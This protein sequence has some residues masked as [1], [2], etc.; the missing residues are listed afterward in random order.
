M[1]Q[2][3]E[4]LLN[5]DHTLHGSDM[6]SVA[7]LTCDSR[8]VTEGSCFFAIEGTSVDGHNYIGK[9]VE[10]GASVIVC[11][12]LP[13]GFDTTRTSAVVVED[14]DKAMAEIAAAY[15]NYPSRK[16]KVVGV[17]GTNG[18]TTIATLLYDLVRLLG[19][20]AGL[21]STVVYKIDEREVTSTH[22]T[23]D[24]IR[25]QAMMHEMVECGCHY[26]FMECSSHA[27]VQ[28]RIYGIEFTGALFTNLTH[29][30]LDYH[31]TFAEYIRA[32]KIFFDELPKGA[33]ALVNADDRNGE[34]M[35][36]NTAARR[37]TLSLRKMADYR[38]KI[39]EK[40]IDG[41]ELKVGNDSV[42]VRFLGKFN[43]TNLLTVYGAAVELGFDHNDV[44]CVLSMLHPV[45][46]RF[47]F[48]KA[49][50]GTTAI[51]D[52]AHTPDA[53]ENVLRTVE[54]FRRADQKITVI[55]GC[56]GDRDRSKR[57][58]MAEIAVKYSD[59]AV[60]T[61]DNPRSEDPA[62]IL[63]EMEE[64]VPAG[65][66]YIKAVDRDEAIKMAVM[67]SQPGDI[68]IIAGKGHENYQ[69][70]GTEKLPFNDKECVSKWFTTFRR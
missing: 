67:L 18:K 12:H 52:Y 43:A 64:G 36:Q 6:A 63:R 54:E 25:L 28:R 34:V 66:R 22:T 56:G 44:L 35:L 29:D 69:I 59:L 27:I 70:I 40:N 9:A 58:E 62:E 60:F 45:S 26:C 14:T 8:T 24:A 23:P 10:A 30:H 53:L 11:R 39:V 37:L 7:H 5:I 13:D 31:K 41:M 15:Y 21:I 3:R 65:S 46:G 1:K 48:V 38:C 49:D 19:H 55:C 32:K 2:L 68:I 42:W 33:F 51:V 57:P 20:K 47:E 61:S 16:M 50:D 4:L 17:T